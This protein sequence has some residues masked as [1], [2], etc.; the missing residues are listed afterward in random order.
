MQF[1]PLIPPPMNPAPLGEE[2]EAALLFDSEPIVGWRAWGLHKFPRGVSSITYPVCWPARKPMR[3][4]CIMAI[5]KNERTRASF[6]ARPHDAPASAHVCGIYATK[7]LDQARS[8]G[9]A[10]AHPRIL[11]RVSLWG[12]VLLFTAGYRAEY[13]Y[14]LEFLFPEKLHDKYPADADVLMAWLESLY[15][16]PARIAP[17]LLLAAQP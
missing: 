6:A 2:E 15:G 13:A 12:R 16:V 4:H 3:A 1:Y 10:H 11:G 7:T 17:D 14:P 9:Q 8:W 5:A